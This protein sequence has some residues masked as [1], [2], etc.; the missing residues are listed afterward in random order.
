MQSTIKQE[1]QKNTSTQTPQDFIG[2]ITENW[3]KSV[4]G[5]LKVARLLSEA[6]NALTKD[7]W[8][9]LIS[10]RLP[11]SRTIAYKLLKVG[12]DN[13]ILNPDHIEILPGSYATLHAISTLSNEEFDKAKT[14]GL[15]KPTVQRKEILDFRDAEQGVIKGKSKNLPENEKFLIIFVDPDRADLSEIQSKIEKSLK[16]MNGTRLE[17]TSLERKLKEQKEKEL[18][19]QNQELLQRYSPEELFEKLNS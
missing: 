7:Q 1:G 11:F 14:Q 4:G 2:Q 15:L 17:P 19:K 8:K 12:K 18:K 6:E 9:D 16:G 10:N 5:I 13:R 3:R